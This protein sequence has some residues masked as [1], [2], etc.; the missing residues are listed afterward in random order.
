VRCVYK[1]DENSGNFARAFSGVV[2]VFQF[3]GDFGWGFRFFAVCF[4]SVGFWGGR[5]VST[6]STALS[7]LSRLTAQ[8]GEKTAHRGIHSETV[9]KC[10]RC[11]TWIPASPAAA[12]IL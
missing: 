5:K 4:W 3:F 6:I 11:L 1:G 7:P 12:T 2:A 8:S 10:L 9:E